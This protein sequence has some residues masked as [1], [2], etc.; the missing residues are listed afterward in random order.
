MTH[1]NNISDQKENDQ[2]VIKLE[3]EITINQDLDSLKENLSNGFENNKE[4]L[5]T[6]DKETVVDIAFVQ[7][8]TAAKI[9][10]EETGI[11][12]SL[13]LHLSAETEELLEKSDLLQI[14]KKS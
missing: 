4:I 14:I 8:I 9:K 7:L 6:S 1:K 5:L 10:A 3:K 12:L 13:D 2:M 11:K